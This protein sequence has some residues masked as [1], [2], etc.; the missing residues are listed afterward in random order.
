MVESNNAIF[1]AAQ[2]IGL[3]PSAR[4]ISVFFYSPSVKSVWKQQHTV[5]L[6]EGELEV[7][8]P[9]DSDDEW[10]TD[11]VW[12]VVEEDDYAGGFPATEIS[13]AMQ[14]QAELARI[15]AA[16]GFKIWLPKA[17]RTRVL[18]KW[19]AAPG[20]LLDSLPLA[21]DKTTIATIELIDVLWLRHRSIVRA[22]EVEHTTSIYSGLLRLADLVALQPNINVKL[23]IVSAQQRRAKVFR[24]ILR[25]V[26]STMQGFSLR[27]ACTYLSYE[28]VQEVGQ[29]PHLEHLSE[30]VIGKFA[31]AASTELDDDGAL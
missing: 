3:P 19:N 23:H 17:D 24:E 26:F 29:Q 25:P 30:S 5:K 18:K 13:K 22:F 9:P 20:E 2:S 7:S 12:G 10:D 15:G 31:E 1:H 28:S 27:D 11:G 4:A 8:V 6:P 14:I 16:M 21:F